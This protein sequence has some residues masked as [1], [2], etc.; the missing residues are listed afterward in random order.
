MRGYLTYSPWHGDINNVRLNFESVAVLAHLLDRQIAIPEH[1]LR[2]A[3]EPAWTPTFRPL[4]PGVFLN[5]DS[6]PVTTLAAIPKGASVYEVPP[7][8]ADTAVIVIESAAFLPSFAGDRAQYSF[9]AEALAADVIK[10]PPLLTPFYAMIFGTLATRR[11]AMLH[12]KDSVRHHTEFVY[13]ARR[14]AD[15][16]RPFHAVVVR[17]NEFIQAYP[18]ANVPAYQILA[19][20]AETAPPGARLLIATDELDCGFFEPLSERYQL[21]YV[22]DLVKAVI[23]PEWTRYH[24]SC[25]EQNLCAFAESFVGTRLSTFSAY[26]NRLRGY[27]GCG[28]THVRFTDGTHRRIRDDEQWPQFSWEPSRRRGE[29]LWG[30][31]FREGWAT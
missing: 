30:R 2:Q 26:V 18:Q 11:R 13:A 16:L 27:H 9:P 8:E 12:V 29:P 17:R 5:L 4:H 31:E 24:L 21:F 3:D 25:V 1:L 19:A 7:L 22:R 20:V 6:L 14:I 28:D 23:Q 10:L 15:E